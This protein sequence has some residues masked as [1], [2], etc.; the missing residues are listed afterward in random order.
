MRKKLLT[1]KVGLGKVILLEQS[2]VII[3]DNIYFSLNNCECL[4]FFINC[5]YSSVPK[6][7]NGSAYC[8]VDVGSI[9]AQDKHLCGKT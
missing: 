4:D 6:V 2:F 3:L 7:G 9:P 5:C 8:A 1:R